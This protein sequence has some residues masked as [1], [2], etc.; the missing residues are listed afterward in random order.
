MSG[1]IEEMLGAV[2]IDYKKLDNRHCQM[3]KI[4]ADKTIR[5]T[6][7]LGTDVSFSFEGR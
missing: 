6:S 1:F 5:I 4:L 7:E 3:E 2:M